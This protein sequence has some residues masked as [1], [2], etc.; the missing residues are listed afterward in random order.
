MGTYTQLLYQI[1]FSTKNREKVL[2]KPGRPALF[3]Y[4]AGILKNKK[5]HSYQI[6]GVE[7]HLHIV[8]HIHPTVSV[9]GLVKDIKLASS[10]CIKRNRLFLDFNGWQT[11]YGAFTYAYQEKNQLVRYVINQEE[12]H[13][14]VTFKEELIALLQE[15]GIEYDERY[16]A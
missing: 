5:C 16:L 14:K 1:I 4:I 6:N 15:H 13:K 3:G 9:A 8:T 11:G 10:K 2:Q 7:D 12:H